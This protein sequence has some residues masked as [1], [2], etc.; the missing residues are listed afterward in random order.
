[1]DRYPLG[2]N[3]A[4]ETKRIARVLQIVQLISSQPRSWSRR[5]LAGRFELSERMLDNDLQL[6]RHALHYDLQRKGGGYYFAGGP[7]LRPLQFTIPETLALVLAAQQARATG[8]VDVE[9]IASGMARL[10]NALPPNIVPYLRR[11]AEAPRAPFGPVHERGATLLRLE[12][13]LQETREVRVTYRSAASSESTDRTLAPYFLFPYERSWYLVA[14]DSR[15]D[16]IRMFK[17]DRIGECA[18]TDRRYTRPEDLDLSSY[19][20]EDWGILRNL[21]AGVEPVAVR[22]TARGA[23][24]VRDERWH[25]SQHME[26][27]PDGELRLRFS[28]GITDELMRWV[29]SF[30]GE[31]Q[32]EEPETLRESVHNEARKVL[33]RGGVTSEL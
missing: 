12:R 5:G 25:A 29:L 22:F 3:H 21:A 30:G 23:P 1:M 18:I 11:A 8:T 16:A 28:C 20:G 32:V 27:L 13:A 17:V 26:L 9:P 6:I 10:E 15:R 19:I 4:E 14:H 31:V 2:H 7:P 33:A 24:W